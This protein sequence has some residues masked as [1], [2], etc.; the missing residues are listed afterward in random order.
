MP[1]AAFLR[2]NEERE[3]QGCPAV[4][5]RN[6]AAGTLRTLE[7]SIVANRRL[8][9][10]RLLSAGRG[11][12]LAAGAAG[13]ARCAGGLASRQSAPQ[14]GCIGRG[15]DRS[16]STP[17]RPRA[18]RWATRSTAWCSRW[19]RTPR[20]SGWATPAARRAGPSL[21]SSPRKLGHHAGQRHHRAGGPHRQADSGGRTGAGLHRRHH[22]E[23]RHAAQR[24]LHRAAGPEA[25]RLGQGRAR[26]RRDS[27]SR[28]GDRRRRSS[29][30]EQALFF[31]RTCPE[32]QSAVV[33]AEGEVDFRCVNADCPAKLR[34]SL[35]HFGSR[36]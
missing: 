24:R 31:R 7:P 26:R 5:P 2:L 12:V 29:A 17:P 33:R 25:R 32:C 34:E 36:K 6:A 18:P 30:R 8:D 22:G 20:S 15:D 1:E 16:S 10:L 19:I 27:Q 23:P 21:T 11:R 3:Q 35:L 9:L 13:H 14:A 28:R 4:N